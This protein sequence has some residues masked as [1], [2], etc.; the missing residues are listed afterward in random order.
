M[1]VQEKNYDESGII[2]KLYTIEMY[3]SKNLGLSV[4]HVTKTP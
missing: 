1:T 4:D 3:T 2:R